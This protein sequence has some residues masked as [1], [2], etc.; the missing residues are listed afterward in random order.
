MGCILLLTHGTHMNGWTDA[1][2]HD[3]AQ[4]GA[5][6]KRS[7]QTTQ[8]NGATRAESQRPTKQEGR[9]DEGRLVAGAARRESSVRYCDHESSL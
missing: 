2:A 4:A 3:G 7:L 5:S 9:E 8:A 1:R 6:A